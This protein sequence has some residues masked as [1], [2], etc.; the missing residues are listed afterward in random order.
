MKNIYYSIIACIVVLCGCKEKNPEPANIQP[1]IN[2][3]EP[4][5]GLP[6]TKV[7]ISGENFDIDTTNISFFIEG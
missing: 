7:T 2:S 1:T 3:I 5:V 6:G 4:S